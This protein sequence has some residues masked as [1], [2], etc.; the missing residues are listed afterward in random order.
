M[1]DRKE[2][3]IVTSMATNVTV[4]FL[5]GEKVDGVI[6]RFSPL[7][8]TVELQ[9]TSDGRTVN[10][11]TDE[12]AY[13]AFQRDKNEALQPPRLANL[14]K[15]RVTTLTDEVFL[16]WIRQNEL[17]PTGFHAFPAY[18]DASYAHIYFYHRGVCSIEYTRPLGDVLIDE[19]ITGTEEV[20]MALEK[21]RE[22]QV[23][24]G[25][26]LLEHGK[27]NE[28]DLEESLTRQQRMRVKLGELLIEAGHI[29]SEEL[30]KALAEQRKRHDKRLGDIM[31]EM[32][33]IT[34]EGLT[35][36]LSVKFHLPFVDLDE[37]PINP[38]AYSELDEDVITRYQVLP[39]DTDE[40]TLTIAMSDPLNIE[41]YDAI[42]FQTRKRI[43]QVISVPSQLRRYINHLFGDAEEEEWLQIDH[44]KLVEDDE[45]YD[46]EFDRQ[47]L[48]G[49]KAAPIVRLVNH[50]ILDGLKKGASD[51]HV[52]PQARTTVLAYRVNGELRK[53]TTLD[54]WNEKRM[55]ARI[56]ILAGMDVTVHR[57]P[58]DGRMSVRYQNIER[59]FRVSCIPNAHGE[60]IVMRVLNKD[61][62][63]DMAA[64][65]LRQADAE[66]LAL[67]MRKPFGL[68]L[69]TGPTGSGKSTTLFA[70]LNSIIQLPE[71]IITIEDPVE[72]EIAGA[73][74]IQVNHKIGMTFSRI[75]RNVLRHD[76]D[77]VM[78]GEMRDKE[79]AEIGIQAALTGHLMLSTLHTN[80]AVDTIIRLT[81]LDIPAYL[82]APALI[83]IISQNLVKRLCTECR[84]TVPVDDEM[85]MI[86]EGA[87][88]ACPSTL[89]DAGSCEHCSKTGYVGRVMIYEFLE[90]TESVRS[91]IHDGLVGQDLQRVAEEAG[92][93]PKARHAYELACD[94]VIGR[95]DLIRLLV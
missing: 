38:A 87:G 54:K 67:L 2:Q 75:L 64:L 1:G 17:N 63:V 48:K 20:Q 5:D 22:S 58:Q 83:G 66:R 40:T 92:M 88:F 59:E 50:L 78:V 89:Y 60:S 51:I 29:S 16:V 65:G 49:S 76:P 4:T 19:K 82:L 24:L 69:A 79:T 21:Q 62:A 34:E 55:V 31:V 47:A 37:Y 57:L 70:L 25:H 68:I 80:T 10:L 46:E 74:Q 93:Q 84:I 15:V 18:S 12:L 86:I 42:R 35:S 77:V 53:E 30:E 23:P 95:G 94:G 9:R 45:D 44:L 90:I 52:L 73:N 72:S 7:L 11:N 43:R 36:A 81:D 41:A 85:A 71:H 27:L 14:V 26:I 61:M 13:I 33:L 28:K 6:K 32:G 8:K 56:K 39:V 3:R 91:A